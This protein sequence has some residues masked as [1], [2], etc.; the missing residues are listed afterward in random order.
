MYQVVML[1]GDRSDGGSKQRSFDGLDVTFNC[2]SLR[3]ILERHRQRQLH[4]IAT[5][6]EY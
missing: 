2:L 6:I 4:I 5:L 1:P 3:Q